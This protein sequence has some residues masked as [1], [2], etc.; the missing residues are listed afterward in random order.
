MFSGR[1]YNTFYTSNNPTRKV[2]EVSS[3]VTLM[4]KEG[5]KKCSC[6]IVVGPKFRDNLLG[7]RKNVC[8]RRHGT[9]VE[10]IDLA[11]DKDKRWAVFDQVMNT[12]I[13]P[14]GYAV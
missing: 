13:A 10:W 3:P 5:G 4:V 12:M 11:Q 7:E 2:K 9:G 1:K 6:R 8:G 14:A